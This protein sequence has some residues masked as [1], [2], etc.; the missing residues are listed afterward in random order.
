MK[1][2]QTLLLTLALA[3]RAQEA[4]EYVEPYKP[5]GASPAVK[6]T[7]KGPVDTTR[8]LLVP[9][10]TWAA[11]GVTVNANGGIAANANSPLARALGVPVQLEVIDDFDRQI[12]NYISGRSAFLR[13][14][15]DMIALAAEALKER[16]PGLEPVVFL[17][18]STSTGADGFVGVN[19]EKLSDLKGK[20]I[21]TQRNG[22]HLSLVGNMLQDA[23][24]SA[25][26]VTIKYVREIT[27]PTET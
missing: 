19:L 27:V 22:P 26:D 8:T 18:L 11:D 12:S 3:A 2:T 5:F 17:Q 16:D 14:T 21:V 25:S 13:G 15:A 4:V 23:G 9:L 20:T 1:L 6:E 7:A 24:L 10:I